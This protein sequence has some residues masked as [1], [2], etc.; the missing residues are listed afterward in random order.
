MSRDHDIDLMQHADG[1]LD[2]R[3]V[4]D[5]LG[6][7][8]DARAKV[9]ALGEIG[10][11]V[12]G[13]LELAGD[14]IPARRFDAMWTEIDKQLDL[15]KAP[16]PA[17]ATRPSTSVETR[18]GAWGKVTR[19]LDKKLGYV[20]TGVVSAGAVAA[21]ALVARPSGT[22]TTTTIFDPSP[23]PAIPVAHHPAAQIE[24]L[25]TPGGTGTVL[26]IQGSDDDGDATVIWVTPDDTE[27]L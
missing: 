20:I 8:A 6:G 18:P 1:E 2:D 19:W 9:Q 4:E 3:T 16:E 15:A 23:G 7:D 11:L 22:N 12:R 27:D 10:E 24:D 17:P 25:E 14:A 13:H 21:I 26:R 5:R